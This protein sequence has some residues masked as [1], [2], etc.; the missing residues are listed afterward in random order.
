MQHNDKK[1][2]NKNNNQQ[3][4][5]T[6]QPYIQTFAQSTPKIYAP[7]VIL[8][9]VNVQC[10][11]EFCLLTIAVLLFSLLLLVFF[12]SNIIENTFAFLKQQIFHII[13]ICF[14][15][16]CWCC[17]QLCMVFLFPA[18]KYC[19]STHTHILSY[20]FSNICLT[21]IWKI[22]TSRCRMEIWKCERQK[23]RQPWSCMG[24]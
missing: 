1:K 13:C 4:H 8:H 18:K 16:L 3:W 23:C 12:A 22:P 24:I 20:F 17:M 9:E 7:I 10:Q 19:L 11:I 14:C 15:V 5:A 2:S 21:W 6:L